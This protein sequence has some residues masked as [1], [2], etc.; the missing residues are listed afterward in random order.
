MNTIENTDSRFFSEFFHMLFV[1]GIVIVVFFIGIWLF[2]K[3]LVQRNLQMNNTNKIK[4]LEQR[5]LSPK[6]SLFIVEVFGKT[7][8]ISE[9]INGV[10]FLSEVS[11]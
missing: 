1:L 9:S 6:S 10:K 4:I 3:L 7:M 8:L 5:P 11:E 2:R